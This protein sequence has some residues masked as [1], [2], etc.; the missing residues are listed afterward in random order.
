MIKYI[1]TDTPNAK[2]NLLYCLSTMSDV[3]VLVPNVVGEVTGLDTIMTIGKLAQ[4]SCVQKVQ[5]TELFIEHRG[6]ITPN[7]LIAETLKQHP[8]YVMNHHIVATVDANDSEAKHD[9]IDWTDHCRE[10]STTTITL[11]GGDVTKSVD[12][13]GKVYRSIMRRSRSVDYIAS[14]IKSRK[15]HDSYGWR[16]M[17]FIQVEYDTNDV[18]TI[19]RTSEGYA[20]IRET[21]DIMK[22][23]GSMGTIY[24]I[25]GGI[26]FDA[27]IV[28]GKIVRKIQPPT[29]V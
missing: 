11:Y 9:I 18:S 14:A 24:Q 29:S 21:I 26:V 25:N 5:I 15:L 3:E 20:V 13:C 1:Y 23:M 10:K 17:A 7:R 16:M 22:S 28:D 19:Y 27:T 6:K 8:S 4:R 2:I 12:D